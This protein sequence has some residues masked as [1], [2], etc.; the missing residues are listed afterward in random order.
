MIIYLF[1]FLVV[2]AL[3]WLKVNAGLDVANRRCRMWSF[4]VGNQSC[5]PY[6]TERSP[7]AF[8]VLEVVQFIVGVQFFRKI[9]CN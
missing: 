1:S 6:G 7:R 2:G 5:L 4:N 9:I 8:W 3:F